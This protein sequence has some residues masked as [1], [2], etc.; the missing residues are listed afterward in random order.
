MAD[1]MLQW[2]KKPAAK[3]VLQMDTI[4]SLAS[5]ARFYVDKKAI[6]AVKSN[7]MQRFQ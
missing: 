6:P 5:A 7:K 3:M 4:A 2:C 1:V